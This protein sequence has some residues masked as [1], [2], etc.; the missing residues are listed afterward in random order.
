MGK[1]SFP[2]VRE[3]NFVSLEQFVCDICEEFDDGN[4]IEIIVSADEAQD[5]ITAIMATGKFK[6]ELIEYGTVDMIGYVDEYL[7]S[8]VHIDDS[9]ELFVEKAW[10]DKHCRYVI[11]D[12]S[13]IDIC[14]ISQ[15]VSE[16]LYEKY[17]D[18]GFNI[19]LF[20]MED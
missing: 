19:V 7:I 9:A 6:P 8:L 1:F 15:D 18:E 2:K 20:N 13:I 14:F 12:P 11:N 3:Y 17:V 5:Y 10:S 16:K 4:E